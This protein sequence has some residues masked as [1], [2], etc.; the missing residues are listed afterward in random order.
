[1]KFRRNSR[2]PAL[3]ESN[4]KQFN[5][6]RHLL[7]VLLGTISIAAY[8]IEPDANSANVKLITSSYIKQGK[9]TPQNNPALQPARYVDNI[10]F[11]DFE[12]KIAQKMSLDI[13][14]FC[15]QKPKNGYLCKD[16]VTELDPLLSDMLT[17]TNVSGVVLFAENLV[18]TKQI[19]N[20]T[21]DLQ[22][23]AMKSPSAKPM[24]ISI[25]QE[26]GRVARLPVG[27]PFSGNMS[28]GATFENHDTKYS[29]VVNNVIAEELVALGFN[30]N[31]APVVDVNTNP[32]NPVIN[33]RSFGENPLN[34]AKQGVAAVQALQKQGIMATLKHF[35]GHGDTNV[36]SH[37]GLP[38][39][40]HD[41]ET[42]Q[43][44]D[45]LPFKYAIE[46]SKPA[47][48]MTAHIQYPALD[49]STFI[50]TAGEEIVKPATM[51]RKIL[52]GIL[53]EE[54][55]YEGLIATDALDMA[56]IAHFY[57]P[58]TATVETF[59][60]GSDLAL[61]PYQIRVP[62]DIPKFKQ[63][64]KDVAKVLQDKIKNKQYSEDELQASI[65][66]INAYKDHYAPFTSSLVATTEKRIQEA[67]LVI[68]D[69]K[70]K[71]LQQALSKAAT[72]LLKN[73]PKLIPVA[74]NQIKHIKLI[75]L[76]EQDKQALERAIK[77]S[78]TK[79]EQLSSEIKVS[80]I[81]LSQDEMTQV[82]KGQI[83]SVDFSSIDSGL[84]ELESDVDLVIAVV[85]VKI[86]SI[87]DMGATSDHQ[88]ALNKSNTTHKEAVA[89]TY[90][91]WVE[92][93]LAL[94]KFKGASTLVIAKG[95]P[96]L[97]TPH[98]ESADA[99]LLIFDD[100]TYQNTDGEFVSTGFNASADILFG[101]SKAEGNINFIK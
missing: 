100:K 59:V 90:K 18:S 64:I 32:D 29:T 92:K 52:T 73:K 3:K 25:D 20:L 101:V 8:S 38:L 22:K 67:T 91:Q 49:D 6:K 34:V 44:K 57:E 33:T 5:C 99:C 36:D 55:G 94:S 83:S 97:I 15:H 63:F 56:G 62:D 89:T 70:H 40:D 95:S 42:I 76:E 78:V 4:T 74:K 23:A 45:L 71:A 82:N 53:R 41:L 60:A 1:M 86:V 66:R 79:H 10:M 37:L 19:M 24:F 61:M 96:Y 2:F 30:N 31:F 69:N 11:T 35:P 65:D 54:M 84:F 14:Y 27:T 48:I 87:V 68:D 81:V 72:T 28:V 43:S 13:R 98:L 7:T 12:L 39:V 47:M 46:K 58:V 85:D 16:S 88:K 21:A 26:G 80:A 9:E 75:V 50:N 77:Q 51:S 93:A 17:Q